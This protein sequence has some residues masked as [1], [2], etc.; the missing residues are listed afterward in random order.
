VAHQE[1]GAAEDRE[2]PDEAEL[3]AMLLQAQSDLGLGAVVIHDHRVVQCNQAHLDITGY[4]KEDLLRQH[5]FLGMIAPEARD[6]LRARYERRERGENVDGWFETVIVRKD[7]RH[8]PVE[9]AVKLLRQKGSSRTLLGLLR[10]I[11]QRKLAEE[12]LRESEERFRRA[13]Q[14][15]AV[16]VALFDGQARYLEVNDALCAMLGYGKEELL[17]MDWRQL[18]HPDDVAPTLSQGRRVEAAAPRAVRFTKRYVHRDGHVIWAEVVTSPVRNPAGQVVQYVTQ[19]QDVTAR[20]EAEGRLRR[21]EALLAESQAASHVGSW[22]FNLV[23]KE[24]AWS[25]EM[26]R[27]FGLAPQAAPAR[28]QAFFD[29]VPDEDKPLLQGLG[30]D[31]RAEERLI[32][33][34]VRRPDG[35]LVWVSTR[36]R[37]LRDAAGAPARIVGTTQD[38]T[39]RKL[40]EEESRRQLVARKLVRRILRDLVDRGDATTATRRS[41][42]RALAEETDAKSVGAL[43]DAFGAMNSGALRLQKAAEGRYDFTGEALL[44]VTPGYGAP[45]CHIALGYLEGLVAQL[46]GGAS[47]GAETQ[48]QSQGH[49]A[50]RFVVKARRRS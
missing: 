20:V 15:A 19:I 36:A 22:E 34:R 23:T 33:H 10:D 29:L 8:V 18:T 26:Y 16:G 2:R 14:D 24:A 11:T 41:L 46:E 31:P 39:Q 3:Y 42:G 4:A 37:T 1:P 21:S 13:F 9:I 30:V 48:C 45:T 6:A 27:L 17:A 50:C 47:L 40:A 32:D 35:A 43:L 12:A 25:D 28:F 5:D 44:E 7:G 49:A 38:I